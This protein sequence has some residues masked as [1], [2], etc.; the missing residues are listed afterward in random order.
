MSNSPL[1]KFCDIHYGKSP[2]GFRSDSE[3]K[4][5]MFGTGGMVGYA[6]KPLFESDGVVIPRK[7]SLN[8]P[9]HVMGKYWVI[10]TAYAA[11]PKLGFDAKW[12]YYQL[13]NYDLTK[14]NEATGVPSISRDWLYK[15]EF[16]EAPLKEQQKIVEILTAID[17]QI[18]ATE[19]LIEKKKSLHT[20]IE[21][22]LLVKNAKNFFYLDEL[23][24]TYGGLNGKSKEDFG[25]G[26]YFITYMQV[27][28]NRTS[29][30]SLFEK[31]AIYEN[32]FQNKVRYGDILFTISSETYNELAMASVF[33]DKSIE[34]YLNSF[35]FGYRLN[36]FQILM[37]E[38]ASH[39]FRSDFFRKKII[40]LAQ[41]STR[42]NTSKG[43]LMKLQIHIPPIDKQKEIAEILNSGRRQIDAELK[44]LDKLKLQKQG[45]MQDLLTGRVRV[46]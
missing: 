13:S 39:F 37:P 22:D 38:F 6:T 34:P 36:D 35:C 30:S 45:L 31:V 26:E 9:S 16:F 10:D 21:H 40:P 5:Q 3:T 7:G 27:F 15:T 20:G 12:L 32:E 42:Y 29:N 1:S 8:N 19:K 4:F 25:V 43:A 24:A 14:L 46:N 23:G 28:G 44:L 18:E 33:L 11:L 41:G 17:E 2:N